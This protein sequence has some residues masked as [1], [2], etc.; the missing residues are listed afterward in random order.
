MRVNILAVD[1]T[2]VGAITGGAGAIAAFLA[3]L[4]TLGTFY[5]QGRGDKVTAIRQGIQFLLG[6][7]TQLLPSI[8]SGLVAITDEQIRE[9]RNRLGTNAT[10]SYFLAQLFGKDQLSS[11]SSLFRASA[12]DSNLSST[13]YSRMSEIWDEMNTKSFEFRGALRIFSYACGHLTEEARN[14]CDPRFTIET[15]KAMAHNGEPDDLTEIDDL[16]ELVNKLLSAYIPLAKSRF[17]AEFENKISQGSFF[18]GML[19]DAI[20]TLSDKDLW[21]LSRKDVQQPWVKNLKDDLHNALST[22]M[23]YLRPEL[24]A[25]NFNELERQLGGWVPATTLSAPQPGRGHSAALGN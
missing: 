9:F 22:S 24:P 20:L 15:L 1:W 7:Q 10:S 23:G 19:A 17:K 13:A 3:I 5:L 2:A 16:D 6:K 25:E 11:E 4:A 14:V 8:K 18:V 21:K 12:T